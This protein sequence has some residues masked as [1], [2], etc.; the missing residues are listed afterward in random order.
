VGI[1]FYAFEKYL[2]YPEGLKWVVCDVPRV[3][4]AGREIAA[5]REKGALGFTTDFAE[6]SGSD[7]L[8]ASGSLQYLDETLADKLR[9]IETL[10]KHLLIN[11]TPLCDGETFTTLQN[12]LAS[13]NPYVVRNYD[14][15]VAPLARFGRR[16]V[17]VS[18]RHL[19]DPVSPGT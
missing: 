15:F 11:K 3:I 17:G 16:P 6:A 14:S 1:A 7:V 19:P 10:P 4:E 13:Y 18:R 8:L 12:T 9:G 2:D 5:K